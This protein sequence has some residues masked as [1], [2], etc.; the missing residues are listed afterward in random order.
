MKADKPSSQNNAEAATGHKQAAPTPAEE[1]APDTEVHKTRSKGEVAS[2]DADAT[3]QEVF[4]EAEAAGKAE[5]ENET[6]EEPGSKAAKQPQP[7]PESQ[8]GR[9]PSGKATTAAATDTM[10]AA[11]LESQDPAVE[12]AAP[13]AVLKPATEAPTATAGT[14]AATAQPNALKSTQLAA[15]GAAA[16]D[17][18]SEQPSKTV[19]GEPDR[20][21]ITAPADKKSHA[22][23]DKAADKAAAD[24]VPLV[25]ALTDAGMGDAAAGEDAEMVQYDAQSDDEQ[26]APAKDKT[27]ADVKVTK[28]DKAQRRDAPSPSKAVKTEATPHASARK[29]GRE[30]DEPARDDRKA[31]RTER[32]SDVRLS[33]REKDKE[34]D[35]EKEDRDRAKDSKQANG[36][37]PPGTGHHLAFMKFLLV[38]RTVSVVMYFLLV[39][40]KQVEHGCD[41]LQ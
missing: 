39:C 5:A 31:P 21:A 7:Q 38:Q 14:D 13:A 37:L 23:A 25:A 36:D 34:R 20:Q 6:V 40:C 27:Q 15:T 8:S 16:M 11:V 2:V 10:L 3:A 22:E 9:A 35:R 30:A 29:R 33:Q 18:D 17:I 41:R 4:A 32:R 1:Q 19:S 12:A 26:V 24:A 28:D